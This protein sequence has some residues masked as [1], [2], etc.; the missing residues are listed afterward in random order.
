MSTETESPKKLSLVIFSGSFEKVHYALVMASAALATGREVTLFFTMDASRALLAPSGWR[1]LR[2]EAE[3]A[4]ATSI[5]LSFSTRGIGSFEE[6]LSA[7]A[8]LGAK[9]MVCEMGLRALGLENE[10]T[11]DELSIETGGVV[12]FLNDAKQN[13]EMLFI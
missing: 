12:T 11:R 6:L 13:G 7:C 10:A 3:G 2:T 5:D 9:F 8:S 4:T 1:H